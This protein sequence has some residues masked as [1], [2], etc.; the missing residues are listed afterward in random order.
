MPACLSA[1]PSVRCSCLRSASGTCSQRKQA[2]LRRVEQQ[3]RRPFFHFS[4][5]SSSSLFLE[6][7]LL[8][9]RPIDRWPSLAILLARVSCEPAR[10]SRR[11]VTFS[12]FGE[13]VDSKNTIIIIA[14]TMD[15]TLP[16]GRFPPTP[17]QTSEEEQTPECRLELP[18]E[19][20]PP[21]PMYA[22][23]KNG[24]DQGVLHADGIPQPQ[25]MVS[26]LRSS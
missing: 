6:G 5:I 22:V 25:Q 23:A 20:Y 11:P 2:A 16:A 4:P 10:S 14:M 13:V 12:I 15:P 8:L 3:S 18:M 21:V 19:S 1:L 9:E 24:L 7:N 17:P 26:Q